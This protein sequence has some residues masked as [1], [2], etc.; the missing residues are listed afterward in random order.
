[1]PSLV[2]SHGTFTW[3][4]KEQAEARGEITLTFNFN[5]CESWGLSERK[6]AHAVYHREGV[7]LTHI[8]P[9]Q[10]MVV[11]D[12]VQDFENRFG[13]PRRDGRTRL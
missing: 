7:V 12:M 10:R 6:A 2:T 4:T 3:D 9:E 13:R 11:E 8:T 5:H 1:M